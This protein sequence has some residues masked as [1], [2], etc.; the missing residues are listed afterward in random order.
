MAVAANLKSRNSKRSESCRLGRCRENGIIGHRWCDGQV[1]P[2]VRQELWRLGQTARVCIGVFRTNRTRDAERDFCGLPIRRDE[3]RV[4]AHPWC[5]KGF[6]F[7]RRGR[8]SL[9]WIE[10][11]GEESPVWNGLRESPGWRKLEESAKE[12]GVKRKERR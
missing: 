6:F 5:L 3:G 7:R 1:C 12:I 2:D 8:G 10:R 9:P 11:T 4:V